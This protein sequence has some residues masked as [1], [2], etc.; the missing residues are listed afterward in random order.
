MRWDRPALIRKQT[1]MEAEHMK[2]PWTGD[3]SAK[4]YCVGHQD[5]CPGSSFSFGQ[6]AFVGLS[7]ARLCVRAV[8][9]DE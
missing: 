2:Q 4:E 3:Q 8:C 1:L 5:L 7:C 9:E 6:I